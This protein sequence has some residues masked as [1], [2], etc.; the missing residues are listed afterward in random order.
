MLITTPGWGPLCIIG[1]AASGWAG[2]A[3]GTAA[4]PTSAVTQCVTHSDDRRRVL[5]YI[6]VR[7]VSS[8]FRGPRREHCLTRRLLLRVPSIVVAW[9][10]RTAPSWVA[11]VIS[12]DV[13]SVGCGTQVNKNKLT[14]TD[15]PLKGQFLHREAENRLFAG[16]GTKKKLNFK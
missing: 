1:E 10:P 7:A 4:G 8:F 14:R 15:L 3:R 16:S 6:D 13:P 5:N 11:F 12:Q 2:E 9:S